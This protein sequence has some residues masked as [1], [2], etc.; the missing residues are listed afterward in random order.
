MESFEKVYEVVKSKL[1][2]KR[3]YH[4]ICVMERAIEYAEIYGVNVEQAKLVGIAHDVLKETPKEYRIIEAKELGVELDD[5]EIKALSLIHSKTG[6]KFCEKRFGFS[7][8]MCDAIKYH[9]TGRP[10]MST[11]EKILYL[12]DCTGKDRT[13]E[14]A[15]IGY[16]IA[17]KDLDKAMQYFLGKTIEWILEDK[18]IIHLDTVKAYNFFLK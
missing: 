15:K 7:E 13:Y 18:S 11:L 8:E 4:S 10:N 12:A 16:E 9:T 6:A 3:F 14:E 17:K 1:S 5:I 2:E